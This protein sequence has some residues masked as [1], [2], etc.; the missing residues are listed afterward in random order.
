NSKAY[1]Y[2]KQNFMLATVLEEVVI[3]TADKDV[4]ISGTTDIISENTVINVEQKTTDEILITDTDTERYNLE[5]AVVFDISLE[6][7]GVKVQPNGKLTVSI[8]VPEN[9]NGAKCRV[10]YV[11]ENGKTTN[12]K[13]IYRDGR[14]IFETDHFSNYMIVEMNYIIGDVNGDSR[15]NNK[16]LGLLMQKLNGWSV[17][18]SDT[19]ADVNADGKVNNKDYG[20]L[21]QYINGWDVEI[22]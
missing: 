7:H 21:M 19:V 5:T 17:E 3:E 22:V 6:K 1:A 9:L 13:A 18:I 14:M 16:D 8:A 12:M 10:L 15:I 4:N 2:A 11:D 20:L